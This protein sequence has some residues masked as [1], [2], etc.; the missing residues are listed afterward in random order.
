MA[1]MGFGLT[2][3]GIMA[4]AYAIVDKT[5]RD[6][7]FKECHAGRGW[8]ECFMARQATLTLPTPQALSYARA[9]CSNK[10]TIDDFFPKLG[11]IFGR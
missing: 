1:D 11:V 6:H 7:P 3:K 2:R 9:V 8:Y 10:E 4:M 5:G